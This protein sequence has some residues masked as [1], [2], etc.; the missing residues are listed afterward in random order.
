MKIISETQCHDISLAEIIALGI[1]ITLIFVIF[2]IID[3]CHYKHKSRLTQ[4][5]ERKDLVT[6]FVLYGIVT[7]FCWLILLFTYFVMNNT[8]T[9][10]KIQ[11][12]DTVSL[13]EFMSKYDIM[14][15]NDNIYVVRDKVGV[16]DDR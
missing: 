7:V 4:I 8:Y 12:D 6:S 2:I 5:M 3:I 13:N 9:R 11:V 1:A 16:S 14:S 10:Y 15:Y